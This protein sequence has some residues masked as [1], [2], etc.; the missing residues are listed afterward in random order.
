MGGLGR[1]GSG[2]AGAL[3]P[4]WIRSRVLAVLMSLAM[5][6]SASWIV[7]CASPQGKS[8]TYYTVKKGDNLYRIGKR[9]G[10]TS[11]AIVRA[12]GIDDVTS[13]RVG[14]KLWIPTGRGS[15][16]KGA[17]PAAAKRSNTTE[18][19]RRARE[20]A[21]KEAQLAF[22]WPLKGTLTSSFGRRG[23]GDHEGIDVSAPRGTS[24]RASESGKVIHSGK[25][26]DY[27]KVVIV[28]HAGN[29]RS[30]YAHARKTHVRKGS[31][32][33]KGDRIAEVGSTGNAT[34]PHLHFEIR[35]R[36]IPKNPLLY[37]PG[38]RP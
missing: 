31:F 3:P 21:R 35:R 13:L 22:S 9:Y 4:R 28:K 6:L 19:R 20:E 17:R 27:G 30:V 32:V 11:D 29:F 2:P 8:G 34:A 14:A 25:L 26:G 33:E 24:I 37:L 12:N 1:P 10:V 15:V 16:T 38:S 18:L 7:G 5:A 23:R 36:E